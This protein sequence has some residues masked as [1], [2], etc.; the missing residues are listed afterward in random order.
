MK[1]FQEI[2]NFAWFQRLYVVTIIVK[3]FDG[4]VELVAGLTLL[5]APGLL[6]H[7][8]SY[9]FGRANVSHGHFMHFVAENIARIDGDLAKGGLAVVILFLIT[10]GV[11]KLALVYALFRK[12][13]WAYPY[14]LAILGL[15]FLYQL[16]LCIIQP[17]VG[18]ILFTLLD[19]LIISVVWGEWQKLK[20]EKHATEPK[21][22]V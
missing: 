4:L 18:M 6:H 1:H 11:V 10:H 14:A 22:S 21:S 20:N 13:L 16:Y 15:F 17:T 2:R 7:I 3:G 8:L 12:L 19:A 9:L 5:I